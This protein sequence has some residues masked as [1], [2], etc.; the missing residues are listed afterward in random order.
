MMPRQPTGPIECWAVETEHGRCVVFVLDAELDLTKLTESEQQ[1]VR[2]V[3][4]G[5]SNADIARQ[6]GVSARTIVNQLASSYEKLGI[7]SRRELK[8]RLSRPAS[9]STCSTS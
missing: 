7:C 6:R 5:L 2:M 4:E 9:S 1:V 3:L 8:A